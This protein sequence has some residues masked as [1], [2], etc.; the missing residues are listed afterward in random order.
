MKLS[1]N[2]QYNVFKK[3]EEIIED[4]EHSTLIRCGNNK[5]CS[6]KEITG[7]KPHEGDSFSDIESYSYD[8]YSGKLEHSYVDKKVGLRK[9]ETVSNTTTKSSSSTQTTS[10]GGLK[11][12]EKSGTINGDYIYV[13]GAVQNFGSD[14]YSYVEIKVTYTDDNGN[15]LDTDR[16]YVNSSDTL[17]PKERKSFEIMTRMVGQKYPKYKVEIVDYDIE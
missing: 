15:V 10:T 11:I 2:E 8:T 17:L 14:S 6:I 4:N 12:V 9:V 7:L 16:T 1:P 5:Y 13:R 3:I